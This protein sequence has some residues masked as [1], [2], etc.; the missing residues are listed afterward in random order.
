MVEGARLSLHN[1]HLRRTETL[2]LLLIRPKW[3]LLS[4]QPRLL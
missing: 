2:S 3:L 4:P 1:T